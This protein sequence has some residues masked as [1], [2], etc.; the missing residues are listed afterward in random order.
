M[1]IETALADPAFD[2]PVPPG[3]LVGVRRQAKRIRR[4]RHI[5]VAF[6]TVAAVA[7]LALLVPLVAGS[8]SDRTSLYG[9][10]SAS[11]EQRATPE[12][13]PTRGPVS[14]T[15]QTLCE[16]P[17]GDRIPGR[18]DVIGPTGDPIDN[19]IRFWRYALKV[20][21]PALIAYQDQF[22]SVVVQPKRD[23]LPSDAVVLSSTARQ[24]TE[25]I[26]LSEALGDRVGVGPDHCRTRQEAITDATRVVARV[27]I[28]GWP[29]HV[30][31]SRTDPTAAQCWSFAPSTR[32]HYI[33]VAAV[34]GHFDYPVEL[35][36]IAKPLRGSLTQ[37]WSRA[38]ALSEIAAAVEQSDLKQE[39]KELVHI[40]QVT[41]PRKRCTVIHMGGGGILEF[42]LRGPY[43]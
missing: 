23:P 30:D 5:A 10:P 4:R 39:A 6:P 41:E 7:L 21:P 19:C 3:G 22:G 9:S 43:S 8:G 20:E 11:P 28:K 35:E 1:D 14:Q 16:L 34:E 36:Q 29:I 12:P 15:I 31:D 25:A 13:T 24:A 27:G 38:R 32:H 2:L 42:T 26:H 33:W 18:T 37:C 17:G 40:R